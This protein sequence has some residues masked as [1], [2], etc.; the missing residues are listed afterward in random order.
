M[1]TEIKF[2]ISQHSD[3]R[4]RALE[5][6]ASFSHFSYLN[7]NHIPYL[8]DGFKEILMI[9]CSRKINFNDPINPFKKLEE[10]II[11]N[12]DWLMGYFG[13]DLKNTIEDLHSNHPDRQEFE[14]ISFYNPIHIL[15]FHD[16][17]VHIASLEDPERIFNSILSFS[18]AQPLIKKIA[19]KPAISKNKYLSNV[20][21]LKDH[22]LEGDIYEVNY[23]MEF[24]AENVVIDPI[25]VYRRLNHLSPM[26]FSA[27][28][29]FDNCYLICASP[30]RFLKKEGNQ[31]ISQ[32]I[33]GTARRG[34]NQEEDE[35]IKSALSSDEKEL[36][37]NMMIVDLV[38]N[39]LARTSKPGT[40]KVPEMF[41]LYSFQQVHQLISTVTSEIKDEVPFVDAIR[42]AFPMGSMTGAPK[43][44]A[45]HLIEKYE[46]SKR[47]LYSG[48]MG[49][50]DPLG[51]FDFNVIIRSLLYNSKIKTLS[52]QVGSA[53]TFDSDPEKEYGECM[54][55]ASA[56]IE[57]FNL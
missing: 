28:S 43:I 30:E 35:R 32:P 48:A 46:A 38:R 15:S 23:C 56:M 5:F 55:K 42:N 44:M 12:P 13:Y 45:M 37:E 34:K 2:N 9:G 33:K 18:E 53:I 39:D 51:N 27:F 25:G 57:V 10:H 11:D 50:I 21:K 52:F 40:V 17:S 24:Y 47:G 16:D 14:E 6:A 41:G 7:N 3:F 29:R 26:P 4:S 22:I 8:F 19:F 54:L 36:A 1:R 20:N 31:L 49:Y